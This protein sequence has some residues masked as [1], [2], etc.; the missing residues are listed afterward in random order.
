MQLRLYRA[1]RGL[2]FGGDFLIRQFLEVPQV[3][4]GL[5]F[6]GQLADNQPQNLVFLV[7]NGFL[8]RVQVGV[9]HFNRNFVAVAVAQRTGDADGFEPLLAQK[10]NAIVGGDA[11]QPRAETEILLELV[12]ITE[13]LG[14]RFNGQ[15]FGIV[16]VAHHFQHGVVK[17][18]FVTL[19]Q[20]GKRLLVAT[21]RLVHQLEIFQGFGGKF[22]ARFLAYFHG[23]RLVNKAHA[24]TGT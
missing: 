22:L 20:F 4:Q 12:Q 15:V 6:W 18:L 21:A 9:A 10:I 23:M 14:K 19:H 11:K 2:Q 24:P 8:L 17:R 5:V 1:E 3:Y 7:A 16:H 13:S